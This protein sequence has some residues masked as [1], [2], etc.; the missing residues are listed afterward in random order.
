ML[1]ESDFL[2]REIYRVTEK[3]QWGGDDIAAVSSQLLESGL[4]L[5]NLVKCCG[6]DASL[7]NAETVQYHTRILM[8]GASYCC[9]EAGSY[10]WSPSFSGADGS[11]NQTF[12]TS[13]SSAR[14]KFR[15]LR[16]YSG[17]WR[18]V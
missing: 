2:P 13:Q 16:D 14:R 11:A 17:T 7:P 3:K 10:F 5:A 9:S 4:Y 8:G 18:L 12:R 15:F 6:S 1:V